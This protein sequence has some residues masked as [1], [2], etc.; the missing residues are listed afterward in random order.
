MSYSPQD[1]CCFIENR[2][3]VDLLHMQNHR[4]N[5]KHT[6]KKKIMPDREK[7]VKRAAACHS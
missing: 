1:M 5:A 2:E 6:N 7:R 3:C 4:E